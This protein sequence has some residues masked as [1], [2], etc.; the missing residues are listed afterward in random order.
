MDG[1]VIQTHQFKQALATKP[2]NIIKNIEKTE[3]IC[4]EINYLQQS[5]QF[6]KIIKIYENLLFCYTENGFYIFD[7]VNSTIVLWNNEFSDIHSI[8]IVNNF[9]VNIFTNHSEMF[10]L[11]LLSLYDYSISLFNFENYLECYFV[12][13]ANL[14]YFQE[15]IR[16]QRGLGLLFK[17]KE[18]LDDELIDGLKEFFDELKDDN[19]VRYENGIYV[20]E[21]QYDFTNNSKNSL[22]SIVL[23]KYGS[24]LSLGD[25]EKFGDDEIV[26]RETVGKIVMPKEHTITEED[27]IVRNLFM[28]Y[29]TSKISNTNFLERYSCIFDSYDSKEVIN[30][31]SKLEI[32]IQEN[33]ESNLDAKKNCFM[34]YF[35]YLKPEIIYEVDSESRDFITDGFI[36]INTPN[37]DSE[38]KCE[39]CDF[40]L[41]I[42]KNCLYPEIGSVL[43]NYFWSRKEY[44]KC[45]EIS[46]KVS[47]MFHQICKFYIHERNY[48]KI[49]PYVL[50][51]RDV[52]LF[53][54][55]VD[56]W[57]LKIWEESFKCMTKLK[58]NR[59]FC[60]NCS[61]IQNSNENLRFSWN[62]FL[63]AIVDNLNGSFA[64]GLVLKYSEEIPNYEIEKDFFLKCL[65][66]P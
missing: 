56:S 7:P 55:A 59:S 6:S 2:T 66:L 38:S 65:L 47:F 36:L 18:F 31:L 15:R 19:C 12:I 46:R 64:L 50:T 27:K 63:N 14:E 44:E 45:F 60:L 1:Q 17:L 30:L 25:L 3:I 54:K 34:L 40:P 8:R 10:S 42:L 23:Q 4:S 61:K 37:D 57:N 35:D 58:E 5:L 62:Y 28:I 53:N 43:L 33:G 13:K 24:M 49:V 32:V 39:D 9:I 16:V 22:K 41:K 29:K 21:N 48:E 51:I 26:E 52:N 20:L 11:E